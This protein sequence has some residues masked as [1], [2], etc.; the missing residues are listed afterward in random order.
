[1][2]CPRCNRQLSEA[3]YEDYPIYHCADCG[4]IWVNCTTLRGIIETR[5]EKI[6]REAHETAQAWHSKPIPKEELDDELRCSAC[7]TVLS[8]VVYGY[9]TGIVIDRCPNGCGVWLDKGEIIAL[10]AFD[11]IWDD[12]ALEIFKEKDLKKLFEEDSEVD[13]DEEDR[14]NA[15]SGIIGRLAD[16][17][18]DFLDNFDN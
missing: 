1:M 16:I 14:K 18:L 5:K 6:P 8:R 13:M 15:H 12:R 4:G 17:L 7:G 9:D 11:E 10:Q 2:E 3:K